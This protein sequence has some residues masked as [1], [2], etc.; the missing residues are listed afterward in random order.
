[1]CNSAVPA[2]AQSS[3][4]MVIWLIMTFLKPKTALQLSGKVDDGMV[5]CRQLERLQATERRSLWGVPFAVKDNIDIVGFNTTAACPSFSYSPDTTAA[6]VQVLLDE[7]KS[8]S[9]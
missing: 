5:V 2:E 7:G 3:L 8:A 4:T 9:K 6:A 1:M